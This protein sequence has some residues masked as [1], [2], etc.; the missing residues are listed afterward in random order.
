MPAPATLS[1]MQLDQPEITRTCVESEIYESLL[2]LDGATIV[3][4]GCG[5][6]DH[7]RRIA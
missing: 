5:K 4:L 3:E 2:G 7:T 1:R 6:A